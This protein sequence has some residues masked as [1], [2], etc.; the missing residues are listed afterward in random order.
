LP[1]TVDDSQ[2]AAAEDAVAAKLDQLSIKSDVAGDDRIA[3]SESHDVAPKIHSVPIVDDESDAKPTPAEATPTKS[4]PA[5]VDNVDYEPVSPT[6]LSPD[7]KPA[8]DDFIE[9]DAFWSQF[10]CFLEN[11]FSTDHPLFF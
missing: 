2:P 8:S 5:S 4:A 9:G 10:F 11:R 3:V 7:S 1:P 6:P